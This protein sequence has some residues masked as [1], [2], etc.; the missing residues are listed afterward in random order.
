MSL[1]SVYK[2]IDKYGANKEST[3]RF[4]I[5]SKSDTVL[6]ANYQRKIAELERLIGQKQ[7]MIDFQSKIIELA[8]QE[9]RIDIK[10]KYSDKP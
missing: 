7:V 4:I 9:Y 10:K 3:E 6:I 8:E 1:T 2:W 5:E